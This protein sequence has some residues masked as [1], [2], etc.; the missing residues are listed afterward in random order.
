MYGYGGYSNNE[1]ESYFDGNA[2]NIR[3]KGAIAIT[4]PTA[5]LSARQYGV[6]KVL[7]TGTHFMTAGH[8]AT[9]SEAVSAQPNGI[10]LLFSLYQNG[11][12]GQTFQSF[13][14]S[15]YSVSTY[16]ANSNHFL[17][18]SSKLGYIG[19]KQLYISDTQITGNDANDDTGTFSD[20][21]LTGNVFVLRA[22][23][24]V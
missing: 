12:A 21:I 17:L 13:F 16:S 20:I 2:V 5:G 8:T 14:V 4:S 9:L 24:G 1:G 6:N 11:T 7:W 18:A 23:I 22:V 3:S 19:S 15:K 10:V